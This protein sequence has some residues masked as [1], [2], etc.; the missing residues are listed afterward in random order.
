M[1]IKTA[2]LLELISTLNKSEKRFLTLYFKRHF[3]SSIISTLFTHLSQHK[4]FDEQLFL[5]KNKKEAYAKN[6]RYYKHQLYK[7]ILTGLQQFSN[8]GD[9]IDLHIHNL[10]HKAILLHSKGLFSQAEVFVTKA[11]LLAAKHQKDAHSNILYP[12]LVELK[13][14]NFSNQSF[15]TLLAMGDTQEQY[16]QRNVMLVTQINIKNKLFSISRSAGFN[17]LE[18]KQVLTDILQQVEE[19]NNNPTDSYELNFHYQSNKIA[20]YLLLGH[21]YRASET[22]QAYLPQLKQLALKQNTDDWLKKL[23]TYI[24]NSFAAFYYTDDWKNIELCLKY[25]RQIKANSSFLKAYLFKSIHI[26]Q[27]NIYLHNYCAHK[28]LSLIQNMYSH[29][30]SAID[31]DDALSWLLKSME[32]AFLIQSENYVDVIRNVNVWLKEYPKMRTDLQ[33]YFRVFLL[34]ALYETQNTSTLEYELVNCNRFFIKN[35]LPSIYMDITQFF[36]ALN[37]ADKRLRLK[38]IKDFQHTLSTHNDAAIFQNG[39]FTY[40]FKKHKAK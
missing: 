9:S 4:K 19:I 14:H 36:T 15:N 12:F 18:S 3:S 23:A 8:Q 34:I 29:N 25:A 39:V 24:D 17:Q 38:M 5:E 35:K 1:Y 22:A 31:K 27:L 11:M 32:L 30:K 20:V 10:H 13:R 6:F 28:G 37:R 16:A 26:M 21:Y 40:W 7:H 33:A 2:Q